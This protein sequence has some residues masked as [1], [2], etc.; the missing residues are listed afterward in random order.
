MTI[1]EAKL[2]GWKKHRQG[3]WT[4]YLL[5]QVCISEGTL[6]SHWTIADFH[7]ALVG[8]GITQ[9]TREIEKMVSLVKTTLNLW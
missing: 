1:K 2:L 5:P 4:H 8:E 9:K 3:S 7:Q 6:Q